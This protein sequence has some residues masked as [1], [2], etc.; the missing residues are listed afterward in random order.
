MGESSAS[1]SGEETEFLAKGVPRELR[2]KGR[3]FGAGPF[4]LMVVSGGGVVV[5]QSSSYPKGSFGLS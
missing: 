1:W 3:P 4:A 2:A 5:V